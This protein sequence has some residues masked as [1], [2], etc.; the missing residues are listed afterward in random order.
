[1][2]AVAGRKKSIVS[3]AGLQIDTPIANN[4]VLNQGAISSLYQECSRLRA[5]LVSVKGFQDYFA[6]CNSYNSRQSTDPVT[7]LW[8]LFSFGIPLCYIFDQL[9]DDE[10]FAK[11][12]NSAFN[13]EQFDANPD[14]AKKHAIALFAMQI[15]SEKVKQL[16]PKCELFTVTDLWDRGSNDGLVKVRTGY[17]ISTLTLS[18]ILAQ[19]VKTVKAIVEH[20]P[21]TAFDDA[22]PSPPYLSTHESQD[23]FAVD[24]TAPVPTNAQESARNNIVREMVETERKYVQDLEIMQVCGRSP[25]SLCGLTSPSSL[26]NMLPLYLRVIS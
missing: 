14:R 25:D 23:S 6:L 21:P 10:G 17:F 1:M 2:A 19:V 15:R 18:Y 12:N 22:P 9:P 16:I 8:D 26:S 24:P 4:T 3:S 11:I 7:Q 5:R 13:Q 20:L